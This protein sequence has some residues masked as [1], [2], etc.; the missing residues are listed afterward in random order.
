MRES[1]ISGSL[2]AMRYNTTIAIKNRMDGTERDKLTAIL[3]ELDQSEL[4]LGCGDDEVG[5]NT[6]N[7]DAEAE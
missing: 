6:V 3:I 4:D 2:R 1:S 7:D 5:F